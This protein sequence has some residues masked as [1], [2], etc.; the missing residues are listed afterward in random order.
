MVKKVYS[1]VIFSLLP[2][3]AIVVALTLY[4]FEHV[5]LKKKSYLIMDICFVMYVLLSSFPFDFVCFRF[6]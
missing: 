5:R 1:G 2:V 6:R 4:N 3:N